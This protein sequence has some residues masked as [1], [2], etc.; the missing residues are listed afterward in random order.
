[1]KNHSLRSAPKP[2]TPA[3]RA[4]SPILPPGLS[5]AEVVARWLAATTLAEYR[6]EA[7]RLFWYARQTGVPISVETGDGTVRGCVSVGEGAGPDGG[8]RAP[9][10]CINALAASLL[11][12]RAG[13]CSGRGAGRAR[14]VGQHGPCGHAD[15]RTFNQMSTMSRHGARSRQ[16][17][18]DKLS[19]HALLCR[20]FLRRTCHAASDRSMLECSAVAMCAGSSQRR[21]SDGSLLPRPFSDQSFVN[22]YAASVS[23]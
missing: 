5:D 9:A 3:N 20:L 11:R 13:C 8:C 6:T 17:R 18:P 16:H 23:T 12:E 2:T 22:A 21:L 14:R 15:M 10:R 19:G 1:M 7:E 4:I